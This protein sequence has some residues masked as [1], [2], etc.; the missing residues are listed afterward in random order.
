MVIPLAL[1][2]ACGGGG[3][4]KSGSLPPT[5][6]TPQSKKTGTAT[7]S[8]KLP[9][10]N[11][12]ARVRRPYYQSQATQGVAIDW[13]STNP[14]TPDYAAPIS[15]ACPLPASVPPGVVSCTIDG[16]GNTDYTFQLQIP[17]GNY[18]HFTVTTFDAQPVSGGFTGSML[19][20]GQLAAPVVITAGATNTIP[21]LTFYGVPA[22][23]SFQPGPAQSHVV[24]Y[25]GNV[26][27]IGN[28][29]QTFFAQA[30]DADGFVI[31]STDSGA[32]A[33]TVAEAAADSPQE[34]TVAT[35]AIP[36]AFTLTAINASG[37]ASIDLTAT[38][39]G[40]GLSATTDSV[41]VT[42]IQELWTSQS[43]GSGTP[44][45]YG[46]PL[47]PP[48]YTPT[49][50]L[51][52]ANPVF[53][54]CSGQCDWAD[55]GVAPNGSVWVYES[56]NAAFYVFSTGAG[57]QGIIS[58]SSSTLSFSSPQGFTID[59]QG[60]V[61]V[62]QNSTSNI[63]V[64]NS[65]GTLLTSFTD[66]DGVP[67]DVAVAPANVA[68]GMAGT[69][70]VADSAGI[71]VFTAYAGTA[72]TLIKQLATAAP[73]ELSFDPSGNLWILDSESASLTSY[74]ISSGGGA[75]IGQNATTGSNVVPGG[76]GTPFG[77]SA[78][79]SVW[80]GAPASSTGMFAFTRSGSSITLGS[81]ITSVGSTNLSDVYSAMI[82]P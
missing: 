4:G 64:Y 38:P 32:P 8:F 53:A 59:S 26:A 34:F 44:G 10:K 1:L 82:A 56:Y 22:S 51:D 68:S 58:P 74:T 46:F 62:P 13:I 33:I 28:A 47:Y 55:A 65:S 27:V 63:Y 70:W 48:S 60:R 69:I 71:S 6:N 23:V 31:D 20:Q 25:G 42:P 11:T 61:Y 24:T 9:G 77:V 57:S 35:T 50:I 75:A 29:P 14:T 79:G 19:A 41:T 54:G 80:L 21:A 7:F 49:S 67:F 40:T 45:V 78:Q 2:T 81:S 37:N 18:P 16:Q 72:P 3:G 30:E 12:M 39:G 43:S 36:Y 17:A 76:Y 73:T 15:A 66:T 52:Y 5:G